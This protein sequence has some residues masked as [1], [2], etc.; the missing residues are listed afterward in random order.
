M[1]YAGL[2]AGDTDLAYRIYTAHFPGPWST[3]T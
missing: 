1:W 2:A 3:G